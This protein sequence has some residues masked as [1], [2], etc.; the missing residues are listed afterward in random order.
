M[1]DKAYFDLVAHV[2]ERG[3]PG[4]SRAGPT[5]QTV[6]ACVR[7]PVTEAAPHGHAVDAYCFPLLTRKHVSFRNVATELLWFARGE[8]SAAWLEARNVRIWSADADK[9]A[10]RGFPEY[11]AA[12]EL[13]PIYGFQWKQQLPAVIDGLRRDPFGRRH[14]VVAWN[15]G[16]VPRMALPPCHYAFQLVAQHAAPGARPSLS[17]V[18]SM[19]SGDVGLGVPYNI[20]SYALLLCLVSRS[21]NMTPAEVVINIADAH[22]Y[23]SH[24]PAL[25]EMLSRP[26]FDAPTLRLPAGMNWEE[27][28][29]LGD[30]P[31]TT[32]A[33]TDWM[34]RYEHAGKLALPLQV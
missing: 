12:R 22:I 33:F 26:C 17:C 8:T 28:S 31:E 24:V 34:M 6:G 21:V 20:A 29:R 7:V 18:V 15:P 4:P 2:L 16:D 10:E 9:V 27:F 25:K 14:M 19:R 3:V 11:E 23:E 30:T 13:G 32:P 1:A 5:L